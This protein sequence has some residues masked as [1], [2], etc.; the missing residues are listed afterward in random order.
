M[1]RITDLVYDAWGRRFFD[2]ATVALPT[3]AKVG[4]VGR[5][6]AGKTTLFRLILGQLS[7]GGGE[8]ELPR[9]RAHRHGRPGAAGDAG[10]RSWRPCW[11]PTSVAPGLM[12][13]LETAD[14]RTPGRDLCPPGRHRRRPGAQPRGGD[15]HR[16]RLRPVRPAPADGGVLRRLADAG[17]HG[18]GP[19]RRAGSAAARRADQLP[20]PGRRP[21]AGGATEEVPEHRPGH[22]PRPRAARQFHGRHPPPDGRQARPLPGRLFPVRAAAE[23]APAPAGRH[24][25]E[26]RRPPG[27]S[28]VLRRPLPGQGQQGAPG[29]VA[30]EDDRQAGGRGAGDRGARLALPAA[31]AQEAAAAAADPAGERGCGLRR[32]SGAVAPDPE[33]RSRRP[34]RPPGRQRRRQVDLR[35]AAGRRSGA[36]GRD[37]PPRPADEGG[38]VPPAP[39]RGPRSRRHAAGDHPPAAAGGSRVR[40]PLAPGPVRL[41]GRQGGDHGGLAVRRRAGAAAAEPGRHG[42]RRTC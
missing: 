33:A 35:P 31:L 4:L 10:D 22:Q 9:A 42:P 25:G 23:R 20:R 2:H 17:G 41:S 8:I 7:A 29:P 39:D 13:E 14:A 15:P 34:H 1:L 24:Q 40:A 28:A 30:A 11:P 38:L 12:A 19:V 18:R 26:D 3:G 27:A 16:P 21:L 6:G 32:R 5:N 37:L 36:L